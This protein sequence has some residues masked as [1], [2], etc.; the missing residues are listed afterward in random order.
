MDSDYCVK[1][2]HKIEECICGQPSAASAGSTPLVEELVREAMK[3]A[4]FD[5]PYDDDSVPEVKSMKNE[6]R[7]A[8]KA[9]LKERR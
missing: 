5:L 7:L 2:G 8:F 4:M 3:I 9:V 1:C 6:F